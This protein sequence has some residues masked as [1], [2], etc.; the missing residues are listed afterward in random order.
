MSGMGNKYVPWLQYELQ[1][2]ELGGSEVNTSLQW[3]LHAAVSYSDRGW[4]RDESVTSS[5]GHQTP[6]D[7]VTITPLHLMTG[8]IKSNECFLVTVVWSCQCWWQQGD[9]GLTSTLPPGRARLWR[10]SGSAS[11][12]AASLS[13]VAGAATWLWPDSSLSQASLSNMISK[14]ER[15]VQ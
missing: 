2:T 6:S 11:T 12:R 7:H 3:L 10:G 13:L 9:Q 5:G 14:D 1:C 8:V 15:K 4:V